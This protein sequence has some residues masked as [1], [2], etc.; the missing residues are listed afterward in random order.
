[1]KKGK[2]LKNAMLVTALSIVVECGMGIGLGNVYDVVGSE[3]VFDTG[4]RKIGAIYHD[5]YGMMNWYQYAYDENGELI[6]E[7]CNSYDFGGYTETIYHKSGQKES[8]LFYDDA[9]NVISG[10]IYT[11]NE[12]DDLISAKSY[13]E[14]DSMLDEE[15][16]YD[17]DS[18]GKKII[19]YKKNANTPDWIVS[20]EYIYHPDGY[21]EKEIVHYEWSATTTEEFT[22]DAMGNVLESIYND[23]FMGQSYSY[24]GYDESGT[25]LTKTFFTQMDGAETT[26]QYD[27]EYDAAGNLISSFNFYP[28]GAVCT[29]MENVYAIVD[30]PGQ[31]YSLDEIYSYQE[32]MLNGETFYKELSPEE[33]FAQIE[34]RIYD[35]DT[36]F[37][38]G[39]KSPVYMNLNEVSLWETGN[40]TYGDYMEVRLRYDSSYGDFEIWGKVYY[41]INGND[42]VITKCVDN[43][44]ANAENPTLDL[45]TLP[46]DPS[47][48]SHLYSGSYY[49]QMER[50]ESGN[51][52]IVNNEKLLFDNFGAFN[53]VVNDQIYQ[54]GEYMTAP[55][56]LYIDVHNY[57]FTLTF[58][59]DGICNTYYCRTLE[60]KAAVYICDYDIETETI[61]S[62]ETWVC[63]SRIDD[64]EFIK[65]L[66]YA[67]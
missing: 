16:R 45:S 64:E 2:A 26:Y 40:D 38:F 59:V 67:E 10:T 3:S 28:N 31:Y 54:Y 13:L 49:Y 66:T 25:L 35:G 21:L 33:I 34:E 41:V 56:D 37:T 12:H 1:M 48:N 4:Y 36:I 46:V 22:Y 11:Y 15:Y 14:M 63:E 47:V 55:S 17:Y 5:E 43:V 19:K 23:D 30:N 9:G 18:E 62:H 60:E 51:L 53:Y 32:V 6:S 39:Y 61:I 27:N 29:S 50:D 65:R 8:E 52:N 20:S 42:V 7:R 57:D 44:A 58:C 24:N